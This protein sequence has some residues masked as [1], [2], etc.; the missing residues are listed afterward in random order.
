M[1]VV[2][3]AA[4]SSFCYCRHLSTQLLTHIIVLCS[5]LS[6]HRQSWLSCSQPDCRQ[7]GRDTV[8]DRAEW[9]WRRLCPEHL[10]RSFSSCLTI[11]KHRCC[12]LVKYFSLS[13]L[14]CRISLYLVMWFDISI[15]AFY[16]SLFGSKIAYVWPLWQIY[17]NIS[18]RSLGLYSQ[19]PT[20]DT[21]FLA[22][23][24]LSPVFLNNFTNNFIIFI[25]FIVA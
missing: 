6:W 16:S 19:P 9:C 4:S 21:F 3:E 2:A 15:P 18:A 12:C 11:C 7:F 20:S 10:W 1:V 8:S 23:E 24:V 25:T 13:S 22:R 17:D 14:V 5:R